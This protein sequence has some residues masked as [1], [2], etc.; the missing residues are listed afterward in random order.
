MTISWATYSYDGHVVVVTGAGSGIGRA[1]AVAFLEQGATV[2]LLGRSQEALR[3]TIARFPAKR[4]FAVPADVTVQAEVD[5]AV[6]S[7]LDRFGRIDVVVNNAGLSEPSVIDDF[8]HQAWDRMRSVNLDGFIHVARAAVPMLEATGGNLIA[9][10]SV[11]GLGGDWGQ[12]AYNATKGGV[13]TMV[14]SL[15]LDLGGRGIRVNAI[16]PGFIATRQTQSRLD[17]ADFSNALMNRVPMNRAG[18]PEDVARLALYLASPDAGYITG[19]IIPVD[20][21]TTAS[22]GTPR[23]L[24]PIHYQ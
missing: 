6:Q 7:I 24:R 17:D 18:V 3:D 13:N 8:D 22:T 11:A 4:T 14:Q 16:A 1:I 23:P 5:S 21:G 19:A 12:F 9:I 15:A 10:S 2:C 20:G